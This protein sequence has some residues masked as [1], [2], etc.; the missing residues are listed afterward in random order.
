MLEPYWPNPDAQPLSHLFFADDCLLIG[1]AL[2]GNVECFASIIEAYCRESG[3]MVNL[4]KSSVI[5]SPQT[6][7]QMKQAVWIRLGIQEQ[8]GMLIYLAIPVTERR[9]WRAECRP[10]EQRIKEC[11]EGWQATTLSLMGRTTLV[12][13]ASSSLPVYLLANTIMLISCLKELEQ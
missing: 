4:Q 6:R 8:I 1:W 2:I 12:R 13:S 9:L 5:F 7:I 3:Q 11:L 10:L